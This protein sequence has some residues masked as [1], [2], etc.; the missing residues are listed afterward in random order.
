VTLGKLGYIYLTLN[1]FL[2]SKTQQARCVL[3][4]NTKGGVSLYLWPPGWLASNQLYYNWQF[5]FLFAK[6]T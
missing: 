5:L 3:A 2:L 1:I 4:W 6:Q